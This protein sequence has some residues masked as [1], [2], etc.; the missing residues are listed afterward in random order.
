M[1]H[2]TE[3]MEMKQLADGLFAIR[4]RCCGQDITNSWHTMAPAV[5]N[6]PVQLAASIE[7]KHGQ[8]AELHEAA[9]NATIAL[10][11]MVGTSVTHQ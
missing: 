1:A 5:I 7:W 6:D 3:V 8:V 10:Q 11:A 9:Q 4:V 2:K